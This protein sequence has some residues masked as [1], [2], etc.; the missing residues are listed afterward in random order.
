[1]GVRPR[2]RWAVVG[3]LAGVALAVALATLVQWS[4]GGA[5]GRA[6]DASQPSTPVAIESGEWS[7][8]AAPTAALPTAGRCAVRPDASRRMA[9]GTDG[10][11]PRPESHLDFPPLRRRPPPR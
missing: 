1:M 2:L 5:T 9:S 7:V 6:M 4:L 11:D 8:A 3:A 10:G